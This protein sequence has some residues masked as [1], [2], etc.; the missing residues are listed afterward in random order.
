MQKI[1]SGD[2]SFCP[3]VE[4]HLRKTPTGM[5]FD[6]PHE[7]SAISALTPRETEMFLLLAQGL[8]IAK[9][10]ELLDIAEK[11]AETRRTSIMRKLRANELADLTRLAVKE[12]ILH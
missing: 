12:G 9:A 1:M 3:E 5:R 7:H 2:P 10:A 11:K 4:K 6:P 8:S